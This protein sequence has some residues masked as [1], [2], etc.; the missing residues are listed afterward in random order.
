MG[1]STRCS[2]QEKHQRGLR[3]E[4]ELST[5][6]STCNSREEKGLGSRGPVRPL[7][8]PAGLEEE[9]KQASPVNSRNQW[10]CRENKRASASQKGSWV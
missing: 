5:Y 2:A 3:N 6:G 8:G 4:G 9:E 10:H 1:L 7:L